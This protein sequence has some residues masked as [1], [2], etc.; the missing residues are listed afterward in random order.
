[1]LTYHTEILGSDAP[2]DVYAENALRGQHIALIEDDQG[3]ITS[4]MQGSPNR[5]YNRGSTSL[6]WRDAL[7]TAQEAVIAVIPV[8]ITPQVDTLTVRLAGSMYSQA[9][10][11]MSLSF[12]AYLRQNPDLIDEVTLA[13]DTDPQLVTLELSNPRRGQTYQE[14]IIITMR[15]VLPTTEVAIGAAAWQL[16]T[17]P[18]IL[19]DGTWGDTFAPDA[20]ENGP[21]NALYIEGE[22]WFEVGNFDA[23]DDRARVYGARSVGSNPGNPG[24]LLA[25]TGWA[26]RAIA[27]DV[28]GV[29]GANVA[30]AQPEL[31]PNIPVQGHVHLRHSLAIDRA[32]DHRRYLSIRPSGDVLIGAELSQRTPFR[33]ASVDNGILVRDSIYLDRGARGILTVYPSILYVTG[34]G[35]L[36]GDANPSEPDRTDTQSF[37]MRLFQWES[38]A[39][40]TEIGT[41]TIDSTLRGWHARSTLSNHRALVDA[42]RWSWS[43]GRGRLEETTR[44]SGAGY[45]WGTLAL[46]ELALLNTPRFDLALDGLTFDEDLPLIVEIEAQGWTMASYGVLY[47]VGGSICWEGP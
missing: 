41:M 17:A 11:P 37:R 42:R 35:V 31:F 25:L 40:P 24:A 7:Y 47:V 27:L 4:P 29:D 6:V 13:W 15:N 1:M 36:N 39:S 2:V 45:R 43:Y 20:A 16:L 22:G 14:Q 46:Q 19:E 28:A 21:D 44:T 30:P 32:R 3:H 26:A 18:F 10:S 23:D 38:G 8:E 34:A 5:I 9:A 33:R 12:K